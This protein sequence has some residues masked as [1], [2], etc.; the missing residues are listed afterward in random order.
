MFSINISKA[1]N[2]DDEVIGEDE[3]SLSSD[4]GYECILGVDDNLLTQDDP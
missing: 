1:F 4:S 2:V 3:C